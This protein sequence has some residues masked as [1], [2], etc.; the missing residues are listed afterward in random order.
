[1]RPAAVLA[2]ALL[3]ASALPATAQVI[4]I[5]SDGAVVR[6]DGPAVYLTADL[7]PRPI[8]AT[9]AGPPRRATAALRP[10]SSA[11][12]EA[13]DSSASAHSLSAALIKAVAWRESR[14]R[15]SEISPKGAIGVMQLMPA[16]ARALGV[17][18]RQ[19]AA[20]I[21][22]GTSFL[23]ALLRRYNGDIVR[24]LAAY[25]AGPGAVDR[26]G[27]I[28]PFRETR[29]YVADILDHLSQVALDGR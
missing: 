24:A 25:N 5:G 14:F 4:E 3:S 15:P 18:P 11:I 19:P 2:F 8:Q 17:D 12:S 16:T 26:Y 7:K 28:P 23:A 20:N 6:H 1:V 21:E 29:A 9:A 27:G 13:I 22:G 10:T